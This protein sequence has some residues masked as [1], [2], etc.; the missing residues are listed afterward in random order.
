M[1]QG[2]ATAAAILVLA[3]GLGA[4]TTTKPRFELSYQ[5]PSA[6]ETARTFV[7]ELASGAD[8]TRDPHAG[9][10][11]ARGKGKD[12]ARLHA[13]R[14]LFPKTD[15]VTITP[16][17]WSLAASSGDGMTAV[18]SYAYAYPEKTLLIRTTLRLPHDR[19][20]WIVLGVEARRPGGRNSLAAAGDFHAP[21]L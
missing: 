8:I 7:A 14:A 13:V 5:Y 10:K 17:G 21:S 12:A 18:L 2:L 6:D 11:L 3:G 4:C 19:D 16:T 1:R 20:R 9:A 15:P